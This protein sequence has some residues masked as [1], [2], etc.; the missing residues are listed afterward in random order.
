MQNFHDSTSTAA[1]LIPSISAR[2]FA[3]FFPAA[4]FSIIRLYLLPWRA[5][6]AESRTAL[7][8]KRPEE[9]L[10]GSS[11]LRNWPL[12]E[13]PG[14]GY[15]NCLDFFPRMNITLNTCHPLVS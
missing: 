4:S 5:A 9:R 12:R 3:A 11:N 7:E 15:R 14:L 10:P 13:R 2:R 8:A 6:L 1:T